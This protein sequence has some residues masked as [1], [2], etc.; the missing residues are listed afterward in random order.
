MY[1]IL[2]FC[3]KDQ[4]TIST[5]VSLLHEFDVLFRKKSTLPIIGRVLL[6]SCFYLLQS[7]NI[8]IAILRNLNRCILSL[9]LGYRVVIL[10]TQLC[11]RL[12]V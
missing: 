5:K 6:L 2:S 8:G 3:R 12:V 7:F 9:D 10:L 4:N 1:G 11:D